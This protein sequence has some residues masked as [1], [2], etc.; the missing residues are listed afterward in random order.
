[1]NRYSHDCVNFFILTRFL[2]ILI[3]YCS[4]ADSLVAQPVKNLPALW[5]IWVRSLGWEDSPGEG[6]GYPLE[7]SGLKIP[8][9][10]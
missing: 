5:E 7:Y 3:L 2:N 10:G 1:M 8:R 9:A 6:K 4:I